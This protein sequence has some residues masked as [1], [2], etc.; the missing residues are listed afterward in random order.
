MPRKQRFGVY[1]K[2]GALNP[3]HAAA[4]DQRAAAEAELA[5]DAEQHAAEAKLST[6]AELVAIANTDQ[7]PTSTQAWLDRGRAHQR[8]GAD[9]DARH[10][11]DQAAVHVV[12]E[13]SLLS[14]T[15]IARARFELS[16]PPREANLDLARSGVVNAVASSTDGSADHA[17]ALA[18]LIDVDR[19]RGVHDEACDTAHT[20]RLRFGEDVRFAP[21]VTCP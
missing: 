6:D 21:S 12:H 5:A 14:R 1:V 10:A 18:S 9:D 11:F 19:A 20:A 17:D 7:R 4:R 16:L 15:R 3:K 13:P 8:A 2:E